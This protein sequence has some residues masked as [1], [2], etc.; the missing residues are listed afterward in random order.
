MG[1]LATV[2]SC[3]PLGAGAGSAFSSHQLVSSWLA[4]RCRHVEAPGQPDQPDQ[5]DRPRPFSSSTVHPLPSASSLV[6]FNHQH[7]A[8]PSRTPSQLFCLLSTCICRL[9]LLR[10]IVLGLFTN[11]FATSRSYEPKH[12]KKKT[13]PNSQRAISL[14]GPPLP[15]LPLPF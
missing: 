14:F 9:T 12:N 13:P 1:Q 3:P 10:T 15:H 11:L 4:A 2:R 6:T 5:P 8:L 7:S